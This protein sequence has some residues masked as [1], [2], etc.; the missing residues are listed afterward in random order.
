MQF[1]PGSLVKARGRE[2]IVL[3]PTEPQ[4]LR[5]RPLT[6]PSGQEIGLYTPLETAHAATFADPDPDRLG[7]SAAVSILFDAAHLSPSR[8]CRSVPLVRPDR[9]Q[10]GLLAGGH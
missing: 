1:T 8:Q 10:E 5:L 4:L 3:P 6:I 7:D 9:P 2:W